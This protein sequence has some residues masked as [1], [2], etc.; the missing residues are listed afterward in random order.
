MTY[1]YKS[2]ALKEVDHPE[3]VKTGREKRRAR[4]K[5]QRNKKF[6]LT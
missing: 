2:Y 1:P 4:R 5:R 3:I 6:L